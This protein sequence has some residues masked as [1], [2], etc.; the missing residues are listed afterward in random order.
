MTN[1]EC[2]INLHRNVQSIFS[3]RIYG[4]FENAETASALKVLDF[5]H[6]L[7]L[8]LQP[9]MNGLKGFPI[10]QTQTGQQLLNEKSL[11][12]QVSKGKVHRRPLS[13]SAFIRCADLYAV[14]MGL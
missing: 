12:Y 13:V 8:K 3:H 11:P 14:V 1:C 6:S 7:D 5:S 4:S 10:A 9:K 2:N